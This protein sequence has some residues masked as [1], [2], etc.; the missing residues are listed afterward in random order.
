[1]NR[2]ADFF[3]KTNR[4]ESRIGMLFRTLAAM[5]LAVYTV[6]ERRSKALATKVKSC[7]AMTSLLPLLL[8]QRQR[9]WSTAQTQSAEGARVAEGLAP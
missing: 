6:I 8:L 9:R 4:F 5:A 2:K 3:Y 1:M 7:N